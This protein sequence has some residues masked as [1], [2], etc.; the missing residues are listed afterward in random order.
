MHAHWVLVCSGPFFQ[1]PFILEHS[2]LARSI[3]RP[4]LK[5]W[6][7]KPS[8][9]TQT[10]VHA[11]YILACS[12]ESMRFYNARTYKLGMVHYV[13]W[14]TR[15]NHPRL[16]RKLKPTIHYWRRVYKHSRHQHNILH[17]FL[18]LA[19]VTLKKLY[20]HIYIYRLILKPSP[21]STKIYTK[22]LLIWNTTFNTKKC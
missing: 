18:Y 17:R 10:I 22:N 3:T 21:N 6:I 11:H 19:M 8:L 16:E 7:A 2:N 15:L 1:A 20:I 4:N 14:S 12:G 9:N 5:N 13:L